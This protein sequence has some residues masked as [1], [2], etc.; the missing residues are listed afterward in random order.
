MAGETKSPQPTV[1][2]VRAGKGGRYASEFE[3][4][5]LVAIGFDEAGD[6]QRP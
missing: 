3:E 6:P 4:G 5:G 1:W 2:V